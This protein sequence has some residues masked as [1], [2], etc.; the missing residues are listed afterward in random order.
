MKAR[1]TAGR[2]ESAL[3]AAIVAAAIALAGVGLSDARAA[4]TGT[5]PRRDAPYVLRTEMNAMAF[6]RSTYDR[7]AMFTAGWSIQQW[8]ALEASAGLG[9]GDARKGDG[10][11]HFMLAGRLAGDYSDNHRHALTVAAGPL[12]VTGGAYD[13]MV[14]ARGEAGYEYRRAGG[15]T[16]LLAGGLAF[17]VDPPGGSAPRAHR[18]D[19][20]AHARVGLGIS[21]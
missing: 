18:G 10:N 2:A 7:F 20:A 19:A 21:F 11:G 14:L 9:F 6:S 3:A 1:A 8:L 15:L 5:Y 4:G 13:R 17:V 16:L 12:L